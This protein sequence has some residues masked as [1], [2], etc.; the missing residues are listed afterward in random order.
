MWHIETD[1]IALLVFVILAVKNR[2][3]WGDD[4]KRNYAF[5]V[6]IIVGAAAT[7]ID[8]ISSYAM[9]FA[10]TWL[11]YEG[12]MLLYLLSIPLPTIAWVGYLLCVIY[13]ETW[14]RTRVRVAVLFVPYA[15][16]FGLVL[17]NPVTSLFF[18]LTPGLEYSRGPLFVPFV[19]GSYVFY[20]FA[21]AVVILCNMH[22]L[23][24][25]SDVALMG[26]F[27]LVSVLAVI[28][29]LQHPGWLI[30]CSANA[31]ACL[32]CDATLEERTRVE[33]YARLQEQNA[34]LEV[35][36][37]QAER[38]SRAKADFFSQMS[39]DMRTP[40]NG[41]MG[42]CSLALAEN[43]PEQIHADVRK[44]RESG[45]YLLGLIND[46]L[47][48]QRFD[49]GKMVLE[50]RPTNLR[51]FVESVE[52]MVRT[53]AEEKGIDLRVDEGGLDPDLAVMADPIRLKQVFVNLLSNAI[54]FTQKA[55]SVT[56]RI[57]V[58]SP[59]ASPL[60]C[61]FDVI[62][63]GVGMSREFVSE[64]LF[65]PFAQEP[66][67]MSGLYAGS[68]LGLSIVRRIVEA[69]GGSVSVESVRGAGT[70]FTVLLDMERSAEDETSSESTATSLAIPVSRGHR[71]ARVLL[72]EDNLLN[73]EIA[74]RLLEA[75][76]YEVAIA[77]N[78]RE[79]LD[80]F[81]ASEEGH[82]DLILMDV[83]MP[84]MGG[85]EATRAIR[86]LDRGDAADVPIV[87]MTADAFARER[88]ETISAGMN[89]HL[90]KP[91]D[92]E[93]LFSTIEGWL[94]RRHA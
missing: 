57:R 48:I 67:E 68:G 66:N 4:V 40:M 72:C 80:L 5:L 88:D 30:I 93:A 53:S 1:F 89:A 26:F 10:T 63:T 32:L 59:A 29:Q 18:G 52:S 55:G 11:S 42:L 16:Y 51:R 46:T 20:A 3:F 36:V 6:V 91:V 23:K 78:G 65:Q 37:G 90:T 54:K 33:L 27:V 70:A 92:P 85:L 14:E 31:I 22:R 47:D 28:L 82:F 43:D 8:I 34:R 44:I 39:H 62:D 83:R 7:L 84:V 41:I 35:A 81:S 21:G 61:R 9:E 76:G 60:Q 71:G 2:R 69:M 17:G 13:S 73:A 19:V 24:H 77:R 87:A 38:A 45:D 15:I 25:R 79:G 49:S 86:A 94:D 58:S 75:H 56:F 74:C 12:P 64:R 50:T